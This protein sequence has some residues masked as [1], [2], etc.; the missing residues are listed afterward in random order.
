MRFLSLLP[1]L[2]EPKPNAGYFI[3]YEPPQDK[4]FDFRTICTLDVRGM[5]PIGFEF[6]VSLLTYNLLFLFKWETYLIFPSDTHQFRLVRAELIRLF[7]EGNFR[8]KLKTS[9][10]L[11]II[12]KQGTWKCKALESTKNFT[13]DFEEDEWTDYDEKAEVP[14]SVMDLESRWVRG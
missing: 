3:P 12:L 4:G 13:F 10:S 2:I 6:E 5:E 7:L 11:I 9:S 8:T 14:V 1:D